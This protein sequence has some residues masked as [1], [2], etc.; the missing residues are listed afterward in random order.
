MGSAS[1]PAAEIKHGAVKVRKFG[2]L[3]LLPVIAGAGILL[4]F[5]VLFW[6]ATLS[7]TDGTFCYP[8]DDAFIHMAIGRNI[9]QHGTFG[10]SPHAFAAASS[11]ILWP[12]LLALVDLVAGD[13]LLTPLLL[14]SIFGLGLVGFLSRTF[15]REAPRS[16]PLTRALWVAAIVI[17]IPLP[18][19]VFIGMEHTLHILVSIV[20]VFAAAEWLASPDRKVSRWLVALAAL[21]SS[22]RYES[23]FMVTFVAAFAALRGRARSGALLFG[24]GLAPIIVFGVFSM[25][26]GSP[27]LPTSVLVKGNRIHFRDASDYGDFLGGAFIDRICIE[28][29]MLAALGAAALLLVVVMRR[30]G[31]WSKHALRISI[32][33]L[34]GIAHVQFAGLNWFFRYE[35]Y[36][37]GLIGTSVALF[38]IEAVPS[39]LD[40]FRGRP[41]G[42][43]LSVA[44]II[45]TIIVAGP[46]GR[47]A[48]L[49]AE[50][51]P[52]ASRNIY[53]QQL[54]N[55]RFLSRYFPGEPV[56][57]NDIG[58]VA[59]MGDHPIIDLAGLATLSIAKAKH[60]DMNTPPE[61]EAILSSSAGADV[62]IVYDDWFPNVL[63]K[64]WI[65]VGR[66]RLDWCRSCG[67]P[68][69]SIYATHPDAFPRV[70]AALRAFAPDLPREVNQ[71]GRYTATP[72]RSDALAEG[73]VIR[74]EAAFSSPKL[75]RRYSFVTVVGADG[76]FPYP[77]SD[78]VSA[79]GLTIEQVEQNVL[80]AFEQIR[81]RDHELIEPTPP[82]KITLVRRSS[83][84]IFVSGSVVT[85]AELWTD[86]KWSAAHAVELSG[87]RDFLSSGGQ[88]FVFRETAPGVFDKIAFN[89]EGEGSPQ[90]ESL[91]VV[92]V[93]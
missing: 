41:F 59:Y 50:Q 33:L 36:A 84:H 18:T 89:L 40:L 11:S 70:V 2:V 62:A 71:E 3:A 57:V 29:H 38:C 72:H 67:S 92:Y 35:A 49:A 63:P 44:A 16:T 46:I 1:S 85:P 24:A 7:H 30:E 25:A 54:Q 34:T 42:G 12:L 88:P 10:V 21:A 78:A 9:A 77:Y 66:W 76:R 55:A 82:V 23:M 80:R 5:L 4:L 83:H 37:V 74:I 68:V 86:E 20:F 19:I 26:H 45:A 48:L 75:R 81:E 8:L 93:P 15:E 79:R 22:V 87:G 91:D 60:F 65:R 6:K 32:S 31:L 73:D 47:R 69:A 61:T 39:V 43:P 17:A 56:V 64:S 53:D 52:S 14:N 51:T 90:L 27:F 13:R 28:P 58:A